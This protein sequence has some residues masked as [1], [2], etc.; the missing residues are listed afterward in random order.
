[1]TENNLL[2]NLG[3]LGFPLLEVRPDL[4]V[5]KTLAEVV[6]GRDMRL[7]EGFPVLLVNGAEEYSF[8][9]DQVLA[10]LQ[11]EEERQIFHALVLMSLAMY[12]YYHLAFVW[13]NQLKA[14]FQEE[15]LQQVKKMREALVHDRA[16]EAGKTLFDS[17][18][19]KT[20]F[21][22]Y[23]E[24]NNEKARQLKERHEELSL[25]FALSRLFSPKQKELFKKKLAG[26]ML[27][28]TEKE[29]YSRTVKKKVAALANPELHRLAQK[30][31]DY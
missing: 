18:R 3:R 1:M 31:M 10:L 14:D 6:A 24:E 27:T 22:R 30:L 17:S 8:D 16:V 25:E 29:Y 7:W 5:N 2:E 26:E 4:D 12:Q 20:M 19:L 28:K 23:F 13:M 21:N 11:T 9:Y 15:D